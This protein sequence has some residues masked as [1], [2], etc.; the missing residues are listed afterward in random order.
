MSILRDLF[1]IAHD[2]RTIDGDMTDVILDDEEKSGISRVPKAA[3]YDSI[4]KQSKN[5]VMQFPFLASRSLTYENIQMVSKAGERNFAAF[6]QTI[7]SMNSITSVDSPTEYVRQFH[8][9]SQ[10]SV[11]GPSDVLTFVFNSS[12]P[13][14]AQDLILEQVKEGNYLITDIFEFTALNDIYQ[15]IDPKRLV[16]EGPSGRQ[17]HNRNRNRNRNRNNQNNRNNNNGGGHRSRRD[18]DRPE[19]PLKM[20]LP[21]TI[22]VDAD[23][24]KANEMMP[25]LMSVRMYRDKGDGTGDYIEFIC[26]IKATI[27]PINSEDMINHIVGVFQD[28]GTLFNV[29]RWTTG[30]ISF[31]KDLIFNVEQIK[32]EIKDTRSGKASMWWTALKNIKAKRRL[33]KL[34]LREP[35]LPNASVVIS[36][37]EVDYIKANYGFNILEDESG[38]KLISALNI[39]SLYVVDP[40]S[41]IVYTFVDGGEHYQV[42]TFRSLE[43]DAGNADRQFKDMLKAINKLQ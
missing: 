42:N 36:M 38:R 41:E 21:R 22:F 12:I 31:F 28:R 25:T 43:R 30:E 6:L 10:S 26:G 32:G 35:I 16:L 7:F 27:H 9:N 24:K 17:Q 2:I 5:S 39:L 19:E 11:Q 4:A 14:E 8:Q 13:K 34:T 29:I 18:D 40:S 3:S 37:D 1:D 23:V 15:P 33:N 20:S